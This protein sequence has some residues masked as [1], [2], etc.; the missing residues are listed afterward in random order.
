[1]SKEENVYPGDLGDGVIEIVPSQKGHPQMALN[2][3]IYHISSGSKEGD[4][5]HWECRWRKRGCSGRGKSDRQMLHGTAEGKHCH[6]PDHGE[7][8]AQKACV[9]LRKMVMKLE[10]DSAVTPLEMIERVKE[11]MTPEGLEK[12]P[13]KVCLVKTIR[14]YA[15]KL[16]KM[17]WYNE[18]IVVARKEQSKERS[19][20]WKEQGGRPRAARPPKNWWPKD[21]EPY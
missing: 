10:A 20:R 12:M 5:I 17:E 6:P 7:I 13:S 14:R 2:G 9:R 1:M 8:E 18:T 21:M 19:K 15:L 11:G 3:F 4:Y 16:G